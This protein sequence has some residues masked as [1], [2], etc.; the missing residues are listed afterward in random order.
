MVSP[1]PFLRGIPVGEQSKT[2]ND[3]GSS[4]FEPARRNALNQ[5]RDELQRAR[6]I[7]RSGETPFKSIEII[8]NTPESKA[9]FEGMLKEVGVPGTVHLAI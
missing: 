9:L 1:L 8:T 7:I 2:Y 5:V 3:S 6:T 4:C